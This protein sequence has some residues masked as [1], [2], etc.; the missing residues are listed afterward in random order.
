MTKN[1]TPELNLLF[2]ILFA[3]EAYE[4]LTETGSSSSSEAS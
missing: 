3:P 1:H 4:G 2:E